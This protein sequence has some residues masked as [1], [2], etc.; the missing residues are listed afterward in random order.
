MDLSVEAISLYFMVCLPLL[1]FGDYGSYLEKSFSDTVAKSIGFLNDKAGTFYSSTF[2]CL[3]E[4]C[5]CCLAISSW[6]HDGGLKTRLS[7]SIIS[8]FG[9]GVYTCFEPVDLVKV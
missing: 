6:C 8:I 1:N 4:P 3:N 9:F 7:G 2:I 5:L